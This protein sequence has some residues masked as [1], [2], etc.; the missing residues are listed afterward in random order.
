MSKLDYD[1]VLVNVKEDLDI[2]DDLQDVILERLIIKVVSHFRFIYRQDYV[3]DKYS[4]IIEDCVIK[5]YNWRG[6][7]GATSE[8]VEGHSMVYED[9][10]NEFAQWDDVLRE[11]FKNKKVNSGSAVFL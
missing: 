2:S 1:D 7:E 10:S 8:T 6:A 3:D 4:F 5:R 9:I 11:D